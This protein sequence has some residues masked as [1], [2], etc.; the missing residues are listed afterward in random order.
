[1]K[2]AQ[3]TKQEQGKIS[4]FL[5]SFKAPNKQTSAA[6]LD[7]RNPNKMPN[8]TKIG[9]GVECTARRKLN[10]TVLHKRNHRSNTLI[11]TNLIH[12]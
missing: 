7:F 11:G 10:N 5:R 2:K 1:M 4:R 3:K 8:S 12:N 6:R 9:A